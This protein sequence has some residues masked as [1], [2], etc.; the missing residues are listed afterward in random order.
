MIH[1]PE[2]RKRRV[3]LFSHAPPRS[4][5]I[6]SRL[7]L[8]GRLDRR[9]LDHRLHRR[10]NGR[11]R[12]VGANMEGSLR[13]ATLADTGGATGQATEVVEPGAANLAEAGDLDLVD[14]RRVDQKGALH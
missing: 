7:L 9:F 6:G 4:F 5:R 14:T 12:H 1:L 10:L 13:T 8:A 3:E 2:T 11:S